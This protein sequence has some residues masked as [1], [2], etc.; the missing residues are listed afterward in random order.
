MVEPYDIIAFNTARE[1]ENKMHDDTVAQKFG[2]AGGLVPGVDVYA[3][4]TRA[5]LLQF[6][7]DFLQRGVMSARFL[8]PVYDGEKTT[9]ASE[10]EDGHLRLSAVSRGDLCATGEA[11]LGS[12][13]TPKLP[14]YEAVELVTERS[15]ADEETLKVGRLLGIAPVTITAE[16]LAAYLDDIRETETIYA[17]QGL[18]HPGFYTRL[19]NWALKNNVVLGPWIHVSSATDH[20]AAARVGDTLTVRARVADNYD[21]KGHRFVDLDGI[22]VANGERVI[23]RV[24]HS[25]IYKPRQLVAA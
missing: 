1:S 8:K 20:F 12:S 25:A 10:L 24:H 7:E 4:M 16:S 21:R 2:F 6:G 17:N 18:C 23:A 14:D 19:F 13:P 3:Y 5:P 22:V 15:P 9:V 11:F